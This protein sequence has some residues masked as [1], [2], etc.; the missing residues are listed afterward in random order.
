MKNWKKDWSMFCRNENGLSGW[1]YKATTKYIE[2]L[3]DQQNKGEF[4]LIKA[5]KYKKKLFL[6]PK[7]NRHSSDR[8][9]G[10]WEGIEFGFDQALL[11]VKHWFNPDWHKL[12]RQQ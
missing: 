9:I 3:L 5:I 4:D 12:K 2:S 11:L 10:Y 7:P 1:Q 6:Q 8:I